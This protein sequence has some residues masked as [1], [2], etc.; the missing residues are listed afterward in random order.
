M[1]LVHFIYYLL[2]CRIIYLVIAINT[3]AYDGYHCRRS[4]ATELNRTIKESMGKGDGEWVREKR[5]K[6]E[7]EEQWNQTKRFVT[8]PKQPSDKTTEKSLNSTYTYACN[9]ALTLSPL[10]LDDDSDEKNKRWI[11]MHKNIYMYVYIYSTL[12]DNFVCLRS[13]F[14]FFLFTF[15]LL[16]LFRRVFYAHLCI[17]V[18]MRLAPSTI[19]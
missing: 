1:V 18:C 12:M 19:L 3:C 7:E 13:F 15:F 14:F 9:R 2:F 17:C 8:K 5:R 10:K 6:N 4:N 11:K 16:S